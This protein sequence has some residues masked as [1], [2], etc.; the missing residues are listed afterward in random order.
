MSLASALIL[1][2]SFAPSF[3]D[4]STGD[5]LPRIDLEKPRNH[6]GFFSFALAPGGKVAAG[7]TGVTT[8]RS[9]GEARSGGG[10]VVL[11]DTASGELLKT[12][13]SHDHT[14]TWLA[15]TPDGNRV[16]SLSRNDL[17]VRVWAV[18]SGDL[19][20]TFRIEDPPAWNRP[21]AL[22]LDGTVLVVVGD[23]SIEIAGREV[24]VPGALT[25]HALPDG[26]AVWSVPMS[27]TNA[28]AVSPDGASV[29]LLVRELAWSE[30]EGELVGR[31]LKR[32]IALLD[33]K[34]GEETWRA[35]IPGGFERVAFTP[36]G[37]SLYGVGRRRLQRF[38]IEDGS[39][40][41]DL[42]QIDRSGGMRTLAFESDGEGLLV[43][44]L[45]NG[46]MDLLDVG[47]GALERRVVFEMPAKLSKPAFSPGLDRAVG[48]VGFD[49]VVLDLRAWRGQ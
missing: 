38:S 47:S 48:L 6:G 21:P 18:R 25:A 37:D 39:P 49:P 24:R 3:Q 40:L 15:W 19:K 20:G 41:S 32:Y 12:L 30:E 26:K 11:W 28:F 10:E 16:V 22:A 27:H 13:G 35:D 9:E 36:R 43:V 33:A 2:S 45:L 29:A 8:I 14:P 46:S 4:V 42:I 44:E 17:E 5:E 34:T 1:L 31:S 23:R 7:G